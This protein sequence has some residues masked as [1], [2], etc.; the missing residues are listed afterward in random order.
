MG[1][2]SYNGISAHSLGVEIERYPGIPKPRKRVVTHSISGRNGVLTQ[3]D[4]SYENTTIRYDI[5]FRAGG[6]TA[7]IGY[8]TVADQARAVADWLLLAPHGSRLEDTYD[9]G[10]FRHGTFVGPLDI[11]NILG[12]YGRTTI[13]FSV[14]PQSFLSDGERRLSVNP[15]GVLLVSNPTRYTA[16]PVIEV[17]MNEKGGGVVR[18]DDYSLNFFFGYTPSDTVYFDC[19]L[20]EAWYYQDGVAVSCNDAVSSPNF[21]KIEP[22]LHRVS[23]EGLGIASVAIIPR[24]WRI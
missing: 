4:G 16:L 18:I 7:P 3:W 15:A 1:D 10:I 12:R 9:P 11:E 13:E 19:E 24:W 22:G 2:F 6:D 21:P 17:S 20:M 14:S 5:W 8:Q 23:W